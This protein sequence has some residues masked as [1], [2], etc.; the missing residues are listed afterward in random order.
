M[1]LGFHTNE[2]LKS[3]S[4][5]PVAKGGPGSGRK[6]SGNHTNGIYGEAHKM[7]TAGRS[8][9]VKPQEMKELA[10]R[11]KESA[12]RF[13]AANPQASKSHDAVATHLSRMAD[14][15][16]Y[17]SASQWTRLHALTEQAGASSS[18]YPV[19]K[20]GTGSGRHGNQYVGSGTGQASSKLMDNV[21]KIYD[22]YVTGRISNEQLRGLFTDGKFDVGLNPTVIGEHKAIAGEHGQ[23]A[24]D[25]GGG[26][27][28]ANESDYKQFHNP[29]ANA[30]E[31]AEQAHREAS[32]AGK[33]VI[34]AIDNGGST[35]DVTNA[36]LSYI[37]VAGQANAATTKADA[38][39]P[40]H[41]NQYVSTS[42]QA[43]E[44]RKLSDAVR[45]GKADSFTAEAQ[46]R[47]I[48]RALEEGSK[49]ATNVGM[50]RLAT[51]YAKA[52][53]AHRDAAAAHV[54]KIAIVNSKA[55]AGKASERA[56]IASEKADEVAYA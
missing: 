33:N 1:T 13:R 37:S 31:D 29:D 20:G 49:M 2:L 7:A 42:N 45:D 34:S 52:A 54:N 27:N 16:S 28:F 30:H 40:E 23:I 47:N 22:A 21:G 3:S 11:F 5:Y 50:K 6:P 19:A 48:A 15:R 55:D 51:V 24:E 36:L 56:A 53:Q 32:R 41:E 39:T 10:G 9:Y 17:P 8:D 44:A 35:K 43:S 25:M 12:D 46:H 26:N 18:N 14:D 38:T 4:N